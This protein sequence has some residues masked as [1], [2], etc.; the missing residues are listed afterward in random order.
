MNTANNIVIISIL[1]LLHGCGG[2][3]DNYKSNKAEESEITTNADKT[4]KIK[5]TLNGDKKIVLIAGDSYEDQGATAFDEKGR[6]ITSM[7]TSNSNVDFNR[8]GTYEITYQIKDKDK[9]I[10]SAVRKIYIQDFITLPTPSKSLSIS[11]VLSSNMDINLDLD[12]WEFSDWIEL[13]NGTSD[14]IKL[15]G[16]YLSDDANNLTKWKIPKRT[17]IKAGKYLL[18]WADKKD[19]RLHTN[20]KLSSKGSTVILSDAHGKMID[21]ITYAKQKS[22]ISCSKIDDKIYYMKPSPEKENRNAYSILVRAKKPNF[23]LISG[24]YNG[25]QTLELTKNHAGEIY[26]TT[27]GSAP[28]KSSKHYTNPINIDKTTVVKAISEQR[29]KFLSKVRT[30]TYFIDTDSKLP[31]VSLSIDDKYLNDDM[32]GIYVDGKNGIVPTDAKDGVPKNYAQAWTRPVYIEYFDENKKRVFKLGADIS[33]SGEHSRRFA[34][35]SFSFELDKKYGTKKLDFALYPQKDIHIFKDFKIRTGARGYKISD[36]LASSIVANGKLDIDYQG[37]KIIQMYMNGEYWGIYHIREKKGKDFLI[38]NYPDIGK[39]DIIS[40]GKLKNGDM[41]DF[42][43]LKKFVNTKELSLDENYNE[44]SK[45]IDIDNYIDYMS[46]M[47]YSAAYDWLNNNTRLWKEKKV[48]AKWRWMIDDVDSGFSSW[49]KKDNNFNLIKQ[50]SNHLTSALFTALSKNKTFKSKFKQRF[51]T[52]LNTVFAPENMQPLID[53]IFDKQKEY[54]PL[55]KWA[56]Q[57]A[58][59]DKTRDGFIKEADEYV[60]SVGTFVQE[61]RDI[62]KTQVDN[63]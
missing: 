15:E 62:V 28:T 8:A 33:I 12:Y 50:R 5:I 53:K 3:G 46:L 18:I 57:L 41:D 10:A 26:Y 60:D 36:I 9:T 38:S 7:I 40:T 29:G 61:R 44:I 30:K 63:F 19:T 23:S 31:I 25:R 56:A 6:D 20:F 55:E 52:L 22:D 37:F 51:Y 54:M 48:G 2:S 1:F 35:R 34:K 11:E 17:K 58:K 49:Q 4:E 45:L 16:Y 43:D 47:I 27:D 59:F 32:I 24:H 42:N 14:E 39:I 21:S 13:Y